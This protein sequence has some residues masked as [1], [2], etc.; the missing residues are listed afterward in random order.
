MLLLSVSQLHVGIYL[1]G[2]EG[3]AKVRSKLHLFFLK[4]IKSKFRK[5]NLKKC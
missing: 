5:K 2:R 4:G 1:V 3:Y